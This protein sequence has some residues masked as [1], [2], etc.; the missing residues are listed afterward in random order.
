MEEEVRGA[1]PFGGPPVEGAGTLADGGF[2]GECQAGVHGSALVAFDLDVP[3]LI[4][5]VIKKE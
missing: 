4:L 5:W 3:A 1:G 2:W